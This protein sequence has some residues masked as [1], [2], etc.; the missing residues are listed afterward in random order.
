[1]K[2]SPLQQIKL[3]HTFVWFVF[4][5]L[6]FYIFFA[7]LLGFVSNFTWIAIAL[8]FGEVLTLL[9]FKWYC[10]L[11]LVARKY[12]DSTRENF[13]IYLPEWLAKHNKLI[14]GTL[15]VAGL[16]LVVW[17]IFHEAG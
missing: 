4:A 13:D 12:S 2:V 6:I 11:T 1:M 8:V 9:V 3:L 17:R 16:I 5:S 15:Y 10:P 7:G 14:F